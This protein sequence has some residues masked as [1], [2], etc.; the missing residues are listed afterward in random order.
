MEKEQFEFVYNLAIAILGSAFLIICA[1]IGVIWALLNQK[2]NGNKTAIDKLEATMEAD[3]KE[4]QESFVRESDKM[5][6]KYSEYKDYIYSLY[7]QLNKI[8]QTLDKNI[9]SLNTKLSYWEKYIDP[10]RVDKN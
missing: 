7:N 6:N 9:S 3:K 2:I 5:Q 1:L 8:V 4:L 10:K